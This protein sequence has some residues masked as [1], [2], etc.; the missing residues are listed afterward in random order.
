MRRVLVTG[1]NGYIGRHIVQELANSGEAVIAAVRHFPNTPVPGV[2]YRVLD[3]FDESSWQK[4]L[5][6]HY[7]LCIHAAWENGFQHNHP[8]HMELVSEHFRFLEAL[9]NV[10]IKHIAVLGSMHEVGY[11]EG[12]I[13]ENT[14][15]IPTT[16]YG[17]AKCALKNAL[18]LYIQNNY[19]NATI[20]WL[21]AYYI[22]GDDL[23]NHSVFTKVIMA[24]QKGE[25]EFPF[26]SGTHQFDFLTIDE[27]CRQIVAVT[28]QTEV[29]GV[30]ECCS[31]KPV[32][33]GEK[34]EQFIT[35]QGLNIKLNYGAFPEPPHESTAV[36]G[37]TEKLKRAVA[38]AESAAMENNERRA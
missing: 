15:E 27:L 20:Q 19:P 26:T 8:S 35:E 4:L 28:A 14:P 16:I 31:G 17:I 13:S 22:L 12:E 24:A 21:R 1:G 25:K 3:I 23:H 33:L 18:G 32:K 6:V 38:A 29:T 37:S 36:W 7:D 34:M 9:L 30:I 10:G 5:S 11:H 2:D